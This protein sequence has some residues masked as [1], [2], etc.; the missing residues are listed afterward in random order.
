MTRFRRSFHT[1]WR[2]RNLAKEREL[3]LP[4]KWRCS[5]VPAVPQTTLMGASQQVPRLQIV[6]CD[7]NSANSKDVV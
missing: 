4:E 2:A 6:T 1:A 7:V 3:R 5:Q